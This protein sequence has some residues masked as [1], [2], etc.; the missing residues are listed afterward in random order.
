[1]SLSALAEALGL[2]ELRG[3]VPVSPD[4]AAGELALAALLAL[5]PWMAEVE[6]LTLSHAPEGVVLDLQTPSGVSA[7][8]L[9]QV[10]RQALPS[11]VSLTV[12][13]M[14]PPLAGTRRMHHLLQIPQVY[15]AGLWLPELG[16]APGVE[17]CAE[18]APAL[19]DIPFQEGGFDL[20]LGAALPFA[21]LVAL[22]RACTRLAG[23]TAHI[24]VGT[25]GSS[26]A[27]LDRQ[28]ARRR[29]EALRE[30]LQEHGV[31]ET[32]L[33]TEPK[34]QGAGLSLRFTTGR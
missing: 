30:M 8:A 25:E 6:S 24:E 3:R 12:A 27:A 32:Q 21:H 14:Q 29:A 22:T 20:A 4:P 13:P 5:R 28:L 2:A 34:P 17:S 1:M 31:P 11:R 26:F 33:S 23:L 9:E 18:A 19:S 10:V 7:P 16:F 15:S